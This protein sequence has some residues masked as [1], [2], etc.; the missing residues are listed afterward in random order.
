MHTEVNKK[1]RDAQKSDAHGKDPSIDVVFFAGLVRID[2][3]RCLQSWPMV[4]EMMFVFTQKYEP[5]FFIK[6]EI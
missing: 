3:S 1:K 2:I 5:F 6:E 4:S